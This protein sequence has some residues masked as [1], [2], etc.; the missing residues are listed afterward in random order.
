M[1][2]LCITIIDFSN[3]KNLTSIVSRTTIPI[4]LYYTGLLANLLLSTTIK[5]APKWFIQVTY[6]SSLIIG[7]QLVNSIVRL[8]YLH[9][10]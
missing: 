4:K 5:L 2:T 8:K 3:L 7:C 10:L 1:E 6:D 9:T